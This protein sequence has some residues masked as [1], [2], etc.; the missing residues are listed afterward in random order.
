M[1]LANAGKLADGG[2]VSGGAA[3]MVPDAQFESPNS[4]RAKRGTNFNTGAAPGLLG[5]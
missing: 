1:C 5:G 2:E 4:S 3:P